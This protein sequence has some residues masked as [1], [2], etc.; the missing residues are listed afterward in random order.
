MRINKKTI[1]CIIMVLMLILAA[2]CNKRPDSETL[3][4]VVI[5]N[6]YNSLIVADASN[7][8][9]LYS[10]SMDGVDIIDN[11]NAKIDAAALLPGDIIRIFYNGSVGE[12][13]PSQI[14]ECSGIQNMGQSNAA[15]LEEARIILQELSKAAIAPDSGSSAVS[16]EESI[17]EEPQLN[18][19]STPANSGSASAPA[20]TSPPVATNEEPIAEEPQLQ[21][22]PIA[23]EPQLDED[24]SFAST[25]TNVGSGEAAPFEGIAD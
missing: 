22:E 5:E 16:S 2:T 10:V 14:M 20:S 12:S 1:L 3:D 23:D 21:D 18:E 8:G 19:S 13:F 11:E 15:V 24:G 6:T 25:D 7:S 9:A 17:A 4:A